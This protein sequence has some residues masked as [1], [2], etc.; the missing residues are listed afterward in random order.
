LD[1]WKT[2]EWPPSEKAIQA[3]GIYLAMMRE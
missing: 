3:K 2:K 1:D